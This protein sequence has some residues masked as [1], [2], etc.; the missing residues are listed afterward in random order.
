MV[1]TIDD[2]E[3]LLDLESYLL[4]TD[5]LRGRVRRRSRPP[6]PEELGPVLEALEVLVGP[7]GATAATATTIIAWLRSRR[8]T[9]RMKVRGSGK[10]RVV[11]LHAQ[12]VTSLDDEGLEKFTTGFLE[13]LNA[14]EPKTPPA[15]E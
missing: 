5:E 12:G 6:G 11:E 2:Y 3:E 8:A 10:G 1:I 7:G 14:N 4:D 13:A 9:V 15:K